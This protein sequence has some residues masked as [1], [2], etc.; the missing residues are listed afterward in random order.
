M[1]L[2]RCSVLE[3]CRH[4]RS[5]FTAAKPGVAKPLLTI[6]NGPLASTRAARPAPGQ[7]YAP[8]VSS[9]CCQSRWLSEAVAT[10]LASSAA[11]RD[12]S[13]AQAGPSRPPA[14]ASS[15]T[16]TNPS[17]S[18]WQLLTSALWSAG[19]FVALA[20]VVASLV[21]A[22]PG[23][24][25]AKG[26]GG[27]VGGRSFGGGGGFGGG[28]S[29][30]SYGG[31][32]RSFSRSSYSRSAY[33]GGGYGG[34]GG[35]SIGRTM[36]AFPFNGIYMSLSGPTAVGSAAIGSGTSYAAAEATR[37]AI[38]SL[39]SSVFWIVV[40]RAYWVYVTSSPTG[41]SFDTFLG[42]SGGR[43][44]AAWAARGPVALCRVQVALLASAREEL[45]TKLERL[46]EEVDTRSK[47][48]L[49]TLLHETALLL[50]RHREAF[51]YGAVQEVAA[52]GDAAAE[53]AFD[54][55]SLAERS[56]FKEETLSN[57][58]GRRR[59]AGAAA[60]SSASERR[61]EEDELVVV[62][63]LLAARPSEAAA[64]SLLGLRRAAEAKGSSSN[65][66]SSLAGLNGLLSAFGKQE[67]GT[68]ED[69]EAGGWVAADRLDGAAGVGRALLALS[70]VRSGQVLAVEVLWTP[71][72]AGDA[73]S[74]THLLE[75]YP[76]LAPLL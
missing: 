2:Q 60:H 51:A 29:S 38:A 69:V 14:A 72:Q 10:T 5:D 39:I 52:A 18:W 53:A 41:L 63:L 49:Q 46:A 48:G 9:S 76:H 40:I 34:H 15:P 27:R 47:K 75:D 71:E 11:D 23:A 65:G 25:L 33:G 28:S 31:G 17:S 36:M 3:G 30:R 6:H 59:R 26:S 55:M 22:A 32:G 70:G 62:T 1:L 8:C 56:R 20:L 21:L 43:G 57:V 12:E 37:Y 61:C 24:A 50:L 4:A 13:P 16:P 73:F 58:Q 44:G 19:R 35:F 42:R 7:G 74:R 45:Q 67:K 54:R 68:L 64:S 66:N